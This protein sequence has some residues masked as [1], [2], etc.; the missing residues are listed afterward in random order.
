LD[1]REKGTN[2]LQG[3]S[4]VSMFVGKRLHRL[5]KVTDLLVGL[6]GDRYT[7]LCEVFLFAKGLSF[8]ARKV[9]R[10][11]VGWHR[12]SGLEIRKKASSLVSDKIRWSETAEKA[13]AC[14]F[15]GLPSVGWEAVG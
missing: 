15:T 4:R 10:G 6:G 5:L 14:V 13:V 7:L 11:L 9:Y 2:F 12:V 8:P 1:G 3:R